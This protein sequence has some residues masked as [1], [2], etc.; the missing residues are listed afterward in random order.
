MLDIY[1]SHSRV[2]LFALIVTDINNCEPNPCQNDGACT[3]AVNN[4]TCACV[5]PYTG[6]DCETCAYHFELLVEICS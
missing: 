3:D 1:L 4:Y 2:S 5:V 6:T